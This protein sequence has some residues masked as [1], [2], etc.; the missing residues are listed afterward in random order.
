MGTLNSLLAG[1][2]PQECNKIQEEKE[3]QKETRKKY[4]ENVAKQ[5]MICECGGEITRHAL[6]KHLKSKKHSQLMI[7]NN[8]N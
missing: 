3:K 2:T 6:S 7:I 4:Q 5:P 1:R 8:L